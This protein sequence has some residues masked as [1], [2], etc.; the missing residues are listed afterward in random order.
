MHADALGGGADDQ[1]PPEG[2]GGAVAAVVLREEERAGAE[3]VAEA[4]GDADR[5]CPGVV[6]V[7]ELDGAVGEGLGRE[8]VEA[9]WG[10]EGGS[11]G[12]R[13]RGGRKV[14]DEELSARGGVELL[15]GRG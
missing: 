15:G 11:A 8:K 10:G 4:A 6:D 14:E 9:P 2:F 7:G 3:S 1:K 12:G 13:I 5:G